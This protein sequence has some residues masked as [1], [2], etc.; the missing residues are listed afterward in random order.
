MLFNIYIYCA[1]I[2]YLLH[3]LDHQKV[4]KYTLRKDK[5]LFIR[6]KKLYRTAWPY[7]K[8]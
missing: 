5:M 7:G 2:I 6:D 3:L 8:M 4:L 1:M